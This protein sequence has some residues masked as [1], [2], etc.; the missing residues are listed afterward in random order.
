MMDLRKF[1][2]VGLGALFFTGLIGGSDKGYAQSNQEILEKLEKLQKVI[3][4]QQMEIRNLQQQLANKLDSSK[5]DSLKEEL[6]AS[7]K[8]EVKEET[9]KFQL[10]EWT[11]RITFSGD[12]RLRYEN[13]QDLKAYTQDTKTGKFNETAT[14][15]RGQFRY[16]LRLVF[17]AKLSDEF[18]AVASMGSSSPLSGTTD[19]TTTVSNTTFGNEW[20]QKPN[21]V[22]LAY[23]RYT[24]KWL[25]GLQLYGGKFKPPWVQTDMF[26]DPDTAV[27]GFHEGYRFSRFK[28]FQ[29][30]A[31]LGQFVV[32]E[33]ATSADAMLYLY[34]LGFESDFKV[35]KLTLAGSYYDWR[36][37]G[38]SRIGS[39][40][41]GGG[42][43]NTVNSAGILAFD[44]KILDLIGFIDFRIGK[45]PVRLF[46]EYSKNNAD[47][48]KFN[49][50]WNAGFVFGK[51]E[52]PGDWDFMYKHGYIE[53]DAVVGAFADGD[54]FF[55]NREGDKFMFTY[56]LLKFLDFRGTYFLTDMINK[57]SSKPNGD[58]DHRLQVDFIFRW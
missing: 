28:A 27:E 16:R 49:T 15:N 24:P 47:R 50:A 17:D 20:T 37:M 43:G 7:V 5:A 11:K 3:E 23:T 22:L 32:N 31:N 54:F 21:F 1:L 41:F 29:P 4:N 51:P 18:K 57:T 30:F 55:A 8:K 56:R 44:Y 10:P 38:S 33:V 36:D 58:P 12:L 26:F 25:D 9:E 13:R 19:N 39:T 2:I 45:F 42:F 52:K 53:N 35:A 40:A 34:Q 14:Y 6:Q 46:G 48:V